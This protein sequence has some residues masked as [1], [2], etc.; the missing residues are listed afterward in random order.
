LRLARSGG[1]SRVELAE[2]ERL[3]NDNAG[4]LLEV[5]DEFFHA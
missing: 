2:L 5:W 4:A 3:V 1:M